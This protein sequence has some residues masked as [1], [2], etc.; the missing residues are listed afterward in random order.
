MKSRLISLF[1]F[2]IL[3]QPAITPTLVSYAEGAD[4]KA[5]QI[6]MT[7]IYKNS[8][9]VKAAVEEVKKIQTESAPK[10]TALS[11]E[12]TKIQDSLQKGKDSL[13]ADE[14]DKL[15]SD[16]RQ[17]LDDLQKEQNTARTKIAEKQKAVQDSLQGEID[18]I[19]EGIAKQ[20]GLTVV[21]MRDYLAYTNNL[22]DLTDKVTKA[23][24]SSKV[25]SAAPKK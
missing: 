15:E 22:T 4:F 21:F 10:I 2:V 3:L 11:E 24:D 13:K 6:S 25:E 8:A 16:F 9:K 1:F 12:L 23:L 5:A 14:K 19:V 17:K 18:K 7:E 20:E